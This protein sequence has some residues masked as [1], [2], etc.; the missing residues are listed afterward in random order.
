MAPKAGQNFLSGNKHGAACGPGARVHIS[1]PSHGGAI[2]LAMGPHHGGRSRA[3][4]CMNVFILIYLKPTELGQVIA[5]WKLLH[6]ER[7]GA[8]LRMQCTS[9]A[10]TTLLSARPA[11]WLW[12]GWLS[13]DRASTKLLGLKPPLWLR[14][15]LVLLFTCLRQCLAGLWLPLWGLLWEFPALL[16]QRRLFKGVMNNLALTKSG[17]KQVKTGPNIHCFFLIPANKGFKGTQLKCRHL[18]YKEILLFPPFFFQY[19]IF[20]WQKMNNLFC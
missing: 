17:L 1:H 4:Y 7:A 3:A 16:L 15:T 9:P 8:R 20:N 12:Q 13:Y 14:G 2:G 10:C 6:S 11:G 19:I 5:S 18:E